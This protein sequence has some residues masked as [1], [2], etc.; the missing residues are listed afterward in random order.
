VRHS[1]RERRSTQLIAVLIGVLPVYILALWFHL[2]GTGSTGLT[3]MLFYPLV[4]GGGSIVVILLLLILL[5]GEQVRSLDFKAGRWRSDIL[6]GVG[7]FL[8]F[9]LLAAL[10][11][12]TV[13]R[14][15]P[16]RV[17]PAFAELMIGLVENPLLLFIW[18][19]PVV[20]IGVAGF[21]ELSRVF[22]LSRLWKVWPG[23]LGRWMVILFSAA[24]FGLVHIYQG[25]AGVISTGM[26]GFIAGLFYM[27]GGRVWPLIISHGLY[28]S[29]WIILGVTLFK[30]GL[31]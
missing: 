31:L 16:S 1:W 3:E 18:L 23:P 5:C 28:D 22:M 25:L 4:F 27:R 30:R 10:E 15:F 21:E 19:G 13:A 29:G 9:G 7:L 8:L 12:F 17:N 6:G 14:W 26:L 20:W 2:Q 24:V 11:Q